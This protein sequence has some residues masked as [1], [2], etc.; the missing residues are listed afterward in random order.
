MLESWEILLSVN[1]L[2]HI[3]SDFT[4]ELMVKITNLSILFS[5]S[6]YFANI[7]PQ[8]LLLYE[9]AIKRNIIIY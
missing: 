4:F 6:L 9:N 3:K 7:L 8:S 2:N 5:K 1:N